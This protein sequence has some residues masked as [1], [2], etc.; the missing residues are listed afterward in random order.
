MSNGK[1]N[2]KSAFRLTF[3]VK[4]FLLGLQ[5]VVYT[6]ELEREILF[7]VS[8]IPYLYFGWVRFVVIV[9]NSRDYDVLVKL[10]VLGWSDSGNYAD[11]HDLRYG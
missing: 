5:M 3:I 4:Q 1:D 2:A 6:A 10:F 9:V 7:F 8:W 11:S